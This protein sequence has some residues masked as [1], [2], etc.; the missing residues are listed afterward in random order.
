MAQKNYLAV[1]RPAE[2]K[3]DKVD[4]LL[5]ADLQEGGWTI[6]NDLAEIIRGGKTDYSSNSTSEEFKVTIGNVPGDPGIE[7]VKKATKTGGQVRIWLYER[8]KRKDGKYHGVFG[9]AVV[10]SF[11]MSFDDED[12][13][14]E[15]TLK[16]KWNTAEGTEDN[17]PPEWFEAAGAPTVEYEH[18]GE[19]VGTFEDKQKASVSSDLG[20]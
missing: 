4:A 5:L 14:I 9:Y 6:E 18:F 8:N 1:I 15:L 20:V 17:L 16:I 13:K 11:E 3:L 2:S 12:N 10:E 7:A 19:N